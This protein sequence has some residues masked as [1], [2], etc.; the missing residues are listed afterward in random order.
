MKWYGSTNY[1]MKSV[2]INNRK[3][4]NKKVRKN[5]LLLKDKI[6]TSLYKTQLYIPSKWDFL[7]IQNKDLR[8]LTCLYIY[9][10]NYFFYLP[11]PRNYFKINYDNQTN[12]IELFFFF[13]NSLFPL[14][15]NFFK[16]LFYSFSRVFFRKLRFRGKGYYMY[17]GKRNTIALQFGYSHRI[18]LY[19]FFIQV[20]F[21]TKTIILMFGINKTNISDRGN[22]LFNLRP[23]NVFTGKGIRFSRQI[24]YRK[25]GKISSYR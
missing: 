1:S 16:T 25:T 6:N 7:A 24:I 3:R 8:N 11:F 20:K 18:R 17:K 22:A 21:I 13:K 14:F 15:W 23:I 4:F 10:F 5:A 2:I 12:S 19:S 9:S